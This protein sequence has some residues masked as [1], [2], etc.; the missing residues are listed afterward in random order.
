[1]DGDNAAPKYSASPHDNRS[2]RLD[3]IPSAANVVVIQ[4]R[5]TVVVG[6]VIKSERCC[7]ASRQ[8]L[9][10]RTPGDTFDDAAKQQV[11]GVRVAIRLPRGCVCRQRGH[12]RDDFF[13]REPPT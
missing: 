2:A 11:V 3:V 6:R 13:R 9:G 8:Q 1:M 5:D 4:R 12:Q 7:E 10:E